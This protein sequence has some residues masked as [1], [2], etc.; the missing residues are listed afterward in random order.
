MTNHNIKAGNIKLTLSVNRMILQKYKK[1]CEKRGLIIS[2]QIEN[3]M[4]SELKKNK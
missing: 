4:N 2:K 3:F 1:Y